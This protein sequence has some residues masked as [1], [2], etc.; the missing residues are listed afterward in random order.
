MDDVDIFQKRG[1]A[2]F[3]PQ[4]AFLFS[5]AYNSV[6]DSYP[7]YPQTG[8]KKERLVDE[9]GDAVCMFWDKSGKGAI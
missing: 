7:R 8:S 4:L 1:Y 9:I 2:L 6:T 3:C 5:S